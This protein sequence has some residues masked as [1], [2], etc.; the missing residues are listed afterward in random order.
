M[1]LHWFTWK[2]IERFIEDFPYRGT[3]ARSKPAPM[4]ELKM[5][6]KGSRQV[7]GTFSEISTLIRSLP[8]LL[9]NHIKVTREIIYHIT[10]TTRMQTE[11]SVA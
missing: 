3:D 5:K 1:K 7:V 9:F 8:Q 10:S 6:A 2:D 11:K 4:R